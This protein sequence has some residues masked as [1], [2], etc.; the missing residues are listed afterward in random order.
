MQPSQKQR[1]S[2]YPSGIPDLAVSEHRA[3]QRVR[4]LSISPQSGH[5]LSLGQ[6]QSGQLGTVIKPRDY[7]QCLIINPFGL[8]IAS[9][10]LCQVTQETLGGCYTAQDADPLTQMQA[11]LQL[12]SCSNQITL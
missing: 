6:E 9:L 12:L 1:C 11:I 4:C 2:C 8:F 7:L 10:D 5:K 3:F